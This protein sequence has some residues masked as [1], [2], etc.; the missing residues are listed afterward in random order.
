MRPRL[1]LTFGVLYAVHSVT[2]DVVAASRFQGYRYRDQAISE[3][4]AIGSP[5]EGALLVVLVFNVALLTAFGWGVWVQARGHP[6]RRRTGTILMALGLSHLA[7][8]FFPMHARGE[9]TTV[10]DAGHLVVSALTVT[11]IIAAMWSASR[12]FDLGFRRYSIA[13]ILVLLA[14]GIG[15]SLYAPRVAANLPTPWMGVIERANYYGFMLWI[16]VFAVM[17][18]REPAGAAPRRSA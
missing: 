7:W 6:A 8:L 16:L 3:L 17:L 9:A 4:S 12:T 15:T 13:T 5:L 11:L 2:A 14:A 1:L 10:T 18:L